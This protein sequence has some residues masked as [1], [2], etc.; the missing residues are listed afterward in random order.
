MEIVALQHHNKFIDACF[1]HELVPNIRQRMYLWLSDYNT[2]S[3]IEH[4]FTFESYTSNDYE[5]GTKLSV[6]AHNISKD[7]IHYEEMKNASNRLRL[8]NR[9]LSGIYGDILQSASLKILFN[10]K[11]VGYCLVVNVACWGFKKVPW[12]F[13]ISIDPAF[14]GQGLGKALIHQVIKQINNEN[15]EIMGLAVTLTNANAIQL[16]Q[17]IGF[18]RLDVFYEFIK[19]LLD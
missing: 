9:V 15:Y 11:P 7:Y 18:Q 13:D 16:Y 12:I 10:K 3:D 4:P 6:E 19:P 1:Q 14:H 5:W 2:S 17:K 8:E